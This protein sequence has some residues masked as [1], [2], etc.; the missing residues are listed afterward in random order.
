MIPEWLDIA[1]RMWKAKYGQTAELPPHSE[2]LLSRVS[3]FCESVGGRL[4]SRQVIAALLALGEGAP[5]RSQL[6]IRVLE[7]IDVTETILAG[8]FSR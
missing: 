3:E 6:S 2:A 5:D 1:R 7:P 8:M 4:R